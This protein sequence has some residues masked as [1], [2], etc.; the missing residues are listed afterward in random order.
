MKRHL[1]EFI[2]AISG[3]RISRTTKPALWA[4]VG[5]LLILAAAQPTAYGLDFPMTIRVSLPSLQSSDAKSL[6]VNP[7]LPQ[8]SLASQMAEMAVVA[9]ISQQVEMARSIV[10][11]KKVAKAIMNTDFAWGDDQYSCLNKLWSKESHWNYKAHN[12]R[13]GAHGI[14]QALPAVKMEI[15]SSDWRTNP[16]TQIRWGLHY[17]DLRYDNP[18]AAWAKWRSHRYY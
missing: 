4:T 5:G 7:N 17:I 10:G 6:N 9:G 15:I 13:S 2:S 1:R 11:A 12:Y 8:G 16:V 18:C 3:L 14:A